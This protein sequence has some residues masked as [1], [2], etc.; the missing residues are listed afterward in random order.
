M[1]TMANIEVVTDYMQQEEFLTED[2]EVSSII[3]SE[4]GYTSL[5]GED[6][7][8]AAI[9]YAYKKA[10]ANEH[11]DSILFSRQTDAAEEIAQGLALGLNHV[12]GS[13]KYAYNVYK[14]MDTDKEESY[15]DFAKSIIGISDWSQLK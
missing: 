14:Y 5:M 9:V 13:H 3:L 1:V 7:Q 6:V 11:I 8:A 4:Q 12:D 15:T 10:E 2:G